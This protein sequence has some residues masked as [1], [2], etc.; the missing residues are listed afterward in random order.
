MR[1]ALDFLRVQFLR[2][3]ADGDGLYESAYLWDADGDGSTV[4][5]CTAKDAPDPACKVSGERI[6]RDWAD[7]VNC[8]M[9]GCGFGQMEIDGTIRHLD[10]VVYVNWPCWHAGQPAG[11]NNPLATNET[12]HDATGDT[13]WGHCPAAPG[14]ATNGRR[15]GAVHTL[16]W[17][18]AIAGSG[19]DPRHPYTTP[20]YKRDRGSYIADDRGPS[21]ASG[22][23]AN[24]NS[25]WGQ[26][27]FVR[28]IT[29]GYDT[30]VA[31]GFGTASSSGEWVSDGD[32]KG[33]GV[34]S[35]NQALIG[36]DGDICVTES[37]AWP[38]NLVAGDT[39]SV[40][41]TS[42]TSG[43]A[44]ATVIASLQVRD[45]P[46][47]ADC[48]GANTTNIPIGGQV[49]LGTGQPYG[50]A[51]P[52]ITQL[53]SGF[54]VVSNRSDYLGASAELSG[55]TV[56]HQDPWNEPGGDCSG[57]GVW[58]ATIDG[59][60]AA[61][62]PGG[63]ADFD[64]DTH[65]LI[66]L[67]GGGDYEV[68]DLV[69]RNWQNHGIDGNS[70]VGSP[71]VERVRWFYGQGG[72]IADPGYNWRLRDIEVRESQFGSDMIA[73]FSPNLQVREMR[74]LNSSFQT[75]FSPGSTL[76]ISAQASFENVTV[77]S[78]AFS[79]LFNVSCGARQSSFRGIRV[80]GHIATGPTQTN[81]VIARLTCANTST[82]IQ[83][84]LFD[85][86]VYDSTGDFAGTA[87]TVALFVLDFDDTNTASGANASAISRNHFSNVRLLTPENSAGFEACLF[88][89]QDDEAT[90][91]RDDG[92]PDYSNEDV[93]A[94]N[95]FLGSSI[96]ASGGI[97]DY[98]YCQCGLWDGVDN[99]SG[100]ECD[101]A[102]KGAAAGG[103]DPRGCL[104]FEGN[105]PPPI[106]SCF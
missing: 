33:G 64:C 62:V 9:H 44:S 66:G 18:G 42:M 98:V 11:F 20:G 88:G 30:S 16:G 65:P 46:T 106:E 13:A 74:V 29:F 89:V 59:T 96:L 15:L 71:L 52:N 68:R 25:W 17:K 55:F 49:Y 70:N 53:T 12:L 31:T 78:S 51:P 58:Q 39:I 69:I 101:K 102:I 3:D 36:I 50:T 75:L 76:G 84:N 27:N 10:G 14:F 105:G 85:D 90:G 35:G 28:G 83:Q 97:T 7:D 87:G 19:S 93:F 37:G 63:N 34:V 86:V 23:Q 8:A 47:G 95:S 6:Y 40:V 81:G 94:L 79:R 100:N 54:S 48:N 82:P 67:F 45:T 24:L 26:S 57:V 60:A 104:N 80:S 22:A 5:T 56:M 103:A 1:D 21:W 99:G 43:F 2:T 61:V 92:T 38:G 91:T 32:S 41:G 4:V 72:T 73:G 77:Q